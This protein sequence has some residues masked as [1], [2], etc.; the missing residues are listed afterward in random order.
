MIKE[1][2]S[3]KE[4]TTYLQHLANV[5]ATMIHTLER[6]MNAPKGTLEICCT[7]QKT[8]YYHIVDGQKHYIPKNE[9]KKAA[10]IAQNSYNRKV[11]IFCQNQLKLI[12]TFLE[13][14]QPYGL[15]SIYDNLHP[16]RQA[17]IT[18]H[19]TPTKDYIERWLSEPYPSTIDIPIPDINETENGEF[20]RV[21][22]ECFIANKLY[23]SNIPYKYE[24]PITLMGK[25]YYPDF[26]IMHPR[27]RKII[28]WEHFGRMEDPEYARRTVEKL[29]LYNRNGWIPG[30]NMIV[31][32]ESLG[33]QLDTK[34][35]NNWISEMFVKV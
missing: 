13:K 11:L 8:K 19:V 6:P 3:T 24:Y 18:P 26:T 30:K 25:T 32:F 28:I 31:T 34:T 22:S 2:A 7:K 1:G 16:A 12:R 23:Y 10:L 33:A 15:L 35:V 27:T 20:V 9:H 21:K 4:F 17:L 5:Y 14:F 29:N